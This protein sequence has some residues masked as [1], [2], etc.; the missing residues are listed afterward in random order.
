MTQRF[1]SVYDLARHFQNEHQ[2]SE[3]DIGCLI[4]T[5]NNLIEPMVAQKAVSWTGVDIAVNKDV[6]C[7]GLFSI[8]VNARENITVVVND[9]KLLIAHKNKELFPA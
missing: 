6:K 8:C 9:T 3:W 5:M 1:K 4:K 2:V 7:K